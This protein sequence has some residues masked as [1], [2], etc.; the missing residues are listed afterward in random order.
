MRK[1]HK[2]IINLEK[3]SLT[4]TDRGFFYIYK[5]LTKINN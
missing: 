3:M 2:K 5:T 1:V 4:Y